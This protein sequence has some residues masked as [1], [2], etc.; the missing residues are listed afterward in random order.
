M[1]ITSRSV[2][3]AYFL[4]LAIC[5]VSTFGQVADSVPPTLTTTQPLSSTTSPTHSSDE[6]H[7]NSSTAVYP[8]LP[9][10][11][12]SLNP[13]LTAYVDAVDKKLFLKTKVC[14]RE[15]MLEMLLC[16]KGTKEHESI[17]SVNSTAYVIHGGLLAIGSKP[18][19][20]VQ[21]DPVYR[22]PQ[23]EIIEIEASYLDPVTQEVKTGSIKNW[24]RT[25][26]HRYFSTPLEKLPTGLAIPEGSELVYDDRRSELLW[27]G[28]MTNEHMNATLALSSDPVFQSAVKKL[29]EI[30]I[31]KP[32]DA[33]F[34]FA[35]SGFY[36]DPETQERFYRAEGGEIICVAN[37]SSATIDVAVESSATN[38][39]LLYEANPETVPADGTP[40]LLTLKRSGKS[41]IAIGHD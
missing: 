34:V 13:E 37:F 25:A 38:E 23:G 35:G 21:Y 16:K 26:T 4:A 33:H 9:D 2:F 1:L 41:V 36:V 31:T 19:R 5:P 6:A 32:F 10:N 3:V 7:S 39:S 14:L 28:L 18:G 12:V 17:L 11:A 8:P 22:S 15:G 27:F 29:K 24:M 20:P 30:A 40:I